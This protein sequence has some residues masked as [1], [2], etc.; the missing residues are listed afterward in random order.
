M[1][2]LS[3]L[4]T[5]IWITFLLLWTAG[6]TYAHDKTEYLQDNKTKQKVD[7]HIPGAINLGL[8]GHDSY[9]A[10]TLAPRLRQA[11]K[12]GYRQSAAAHFGGEAREDV[13]LA[14]SS[15]ESVSPG[16]QCPAEAPRRVY[17]ISAIDVEITLNQYLDF[18]TGF[19]FV[20][21]MNI[22]KVR[23]EAKRNEEAGQKENDPGA[24]SIGLQGDMIQPLVIRANQGD[25]LNIILRNQVEDVEINFHLHG[26]S[27]IVKSTGKPATLTNPESFV[28]SGKKKVF[29][30]YIRSD[31]QEGAHHFHSHSR[32]QTSLG[33]FGALIVEP[34][35]SR[36]LD[37]FTSGDLESGWMAMIENPNGPD[38]REFVSFYHEIG[39][40]EYRILNKAV[41][42]IVQRVPETGG[43]RP[44]SRALNY[45]S[46][47]FFN[48]LI[49]QKKRAGF[50]DEA[51]AYSSYTFGD[52][53]TPIP[54]SYVGDPA[55]WRL[56]HGGSEVVHSHH[57]HGGAIRW[58][59]QPNVES[60]LNLFGK[61]NLTLAADGPIKFP[62]VRTTSDRV[63]AQSLNPSE[64]F[65]LE[66]ECGSGGCQHTVGDFLYHCH[67]PQ[68][69]VAGM[70]SFWRV[71]NTLQIQG[72]QTD[73]MPLLQEL[74]DR[75]G[76]VKTAVDSTALV[77][78]TVRWFGKNF[79]ITAKKTDRSSNPVAYSI[80]DWVENQLPPQGKPGNT[81]D[82]KGQVLAY[83]ATV[84]NWIKEPAANGKLLYRNEP[85]TRQKWPKYKP[86]KPDNRPPFLF[87]P[88]S[89]KL[90][91]P[92]LKPHFGKRPP[93][94]PNHGGAPFLEPIA[95]NGN[96]ERST[97]PS[98]PGENGHW[99][100]CPEES[101]I[102][103][104]NINAISLP[105]TLSKAEGELPPIV[106][107]NG[108]IFVL[109]EEEARIRANDDLKFPLIIRANVGDCVDILLKSKLKDDAENLSSSKV[110]MHI[111]FVQF[112]V[113]A[114]DGV[115]TGMSYEQSVRPF[116]MLK[117]D[118]EGL[119]KPQ[120]E[121]ITESVRAGQNKIN[122]A[123]ASRF[124]PG[125]EVGIGMDQ[126]DTFEVRR[127]KKIQKNTLTFTEPLSHSHG[128]GEI[129]SVEF[130]RY[131]WY[132]DAD[133]GASYWHDHAFGLSSWGHGL[134]GALIVE[135]KGSFY[136]DPATGKDIRSGPIADIH[137][138]EPVSAHVRGSFR[139]MVVQIQD[140]NPRT[141]NQIVT[142]AKVNPPTGGRTTPRPIDILGDMEAWS[143][144]PTAIKY[145]N[146]GERTS[147]SSFGMRV[148]PL[149]RRLVNNPDPSL[150]FSSIHGDPAT[151]LLQA[152]LGDPI[153][154]RALVHAGNESH[155]FHLDGHW[156]PGER[157]SVD[158]QHIDTIH[159]AIAERYDLAIPAAGGP[160]KKP[161]D[162][163]YLNGRAS[164]FA[165][166]SWGIIR[167][168]EKLVPDLKPLPGRETIPVPAKRI[169]PEDAPVKRFNVAAI[170]RPYDLHPKAPETIE[171]SDGRKLLLENKEGKL[172][173]LED[174]LT[175][176]LK[177]A[178][179][180]HPFVLRVN[181]GD[182]IKVTLRNA[183]SKERVG[184]HVNRMAYDPK[185]S[186]GINV[187][188][189][190]GDQTV[191]P[192]KK[193]TYTFYAHPEYGEAA[194]LITDWGNVLANP[195]NGLYGAIIIGPRGAT[196]RDSVTGKDISLANNW[197]ANVI[198]DQTV[199]G[200]KHRKN[201]RD[202]V[203]FFQD[204]DNLIGTPF[205]PYIKD[206]AGLTGVNYRT[207]PISWR[208]ELG[209]SLTRVFA[210]AEAGEP[211]T[212]MI[213][214]HAGD[215]IKLHIL[216]PFSE[217]NGVFSIE[218][219]QFPLEP[220]MQGSTLLSSL[221]F[222]AL[223]A[224]TLIMQ[225]GGPFR[226][227]GDYVWM[228]HRMPY[229]EAG[230]W[231][232][233]R[234]LPAGDRRIKSLQLKAAKIAE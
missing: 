179:A 37:P 224:L 226:L 113:Q 207:E 14:A 121:I 98:R 153:V 131:R 108:Q 39:D 216:V 203:L 28:E 233:F 218:G 197:R 158:S 107:A 129:V 155:T 160:Q 213:E 100:L 130:V 87:D 211:A 99:S 15:G 24:V 189:N 7:S 127:I 171:T 148:E 149:N 94:A 163:L 67:I 110:N 71:Y 26:S 168:L 48:N 199:P 65:N 80:E 181:V 188:L 136:R 192:G 16:Q 183:L 152:Y 225:A 133:V 25:C 57:L 56:V 128:K 22:S 178:N 123:N 89:G 109:A 142:E 30:W 91:W 187:G 229:M 219:H 205:M 77:N 204:E 118:K 173:V 29:E 88:V 10:T 11:I 220:K 51:L 106:D 96:G 12:G 8:T 185:D 212:P 228:N 13:R 27:L 92:F 101:K 35:G 18:H 167:V 126:V 124:H 54:R 84:L 21:T 132:V 200:N 154:I 79:N 202:A 97:N 156:F 73:T 90:A 1:Q 83:D 206:V 186:M 232:I 196:Y 47:S 58:R 31:E 9:A 42:M 184:F 221:Q 165:E 81:E 33:L 23:A 161:G 69:Y 145:L 52:P 175:E 61:S 159:L 55:K 53:A 34:H 234:V 146:G 164:H 198:I 193:R 19:M 116:T 150:L 102:K 44:A 210:C 105:I 140:F 231:G 201:Y 64:T 43:Y 111:H 222:G 59:R 63:D 180:P 115:I 141:Q 114:S 117:D 17:D 194:G 166:G 119:P 40:E 176:V 135:P 223:D 227:P 209:C 32:E 20:L 120:N 134:F 41:E 60:D 38:F 104:Y 214:A 125:I 169:C 217:Q 103:R 36:F 46:E 157:Y 6:S 66:I 177:G 190:K 172:Y 45:R 151:P 68:H 3:L 174:D 215:I 93:F 139:E 50:M 49:L 76:R 191:A 78:S 195:R 112:D 182:C 162:Y 208:L 147:G 230:Q 86:S 70:W 143:L 82:E 2:I 62:P 4:K 85:E 74:P 170:E 137:T 122:L 72:A 95:E 144:M 75:K 5:L 138:N